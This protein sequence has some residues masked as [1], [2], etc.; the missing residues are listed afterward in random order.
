MLEGTGGVADRIKEMSTL[1][2]KRVI[3]ELLFDSNPEALVDAC[4]EVLANRT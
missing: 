1:S 4:L 2:S 3:S